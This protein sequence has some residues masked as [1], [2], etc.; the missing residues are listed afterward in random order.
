[1]AMRR[2]FYHVGYDVVGILEIPASEL[3]PRRWQPSI[4]SQ[5]EFEQQRMV[6]LDSL[7]SFSRHTKPFALWGIYRLRKNCGAQERKAE[8]F[9]LLHIGG[10]ACATFDALYVNRAYRPKAVCLLRP[11]HGYGD[12]WTNFYAPGDCL[13]RLMQMTGL[14]EYLMQ[15]VGLQWPGYAP[16]PIQETFDMDWGPQ[17]PIKIFKRSLK[18][19]GI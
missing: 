13:Y 7:P 5:S 12:N 4:S 17:N 14:P 6:F 9:S 1:M 2:D 10:E 19:I 11:G 18:S 16:F 15:A 3:T 8:M